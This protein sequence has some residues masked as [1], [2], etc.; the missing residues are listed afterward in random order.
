MA[1]RFF[2]A[3]GV[4]KTGEYSGSGQP[5]G[6]ITQYALATAPVGWLLCDGGQY[7]V[8]TYPLLD[9]LLGVT[10]GART[11]GFGS[12]GSTHF[13]V[14][15]A[16]GRVAVGAGTGAGGGT[17]GSGSVP[18]GGTA[19]TARSVSA[20]TGSERHTLSTGE[21]GNAAQAAGTSGT[22]SSDHS[23]SGTTGTESSDHTHNTWSGGGGAPYHITPLLAGT[24]GASQFATGGR[25]AA[26][27]HNFSTGGV[28]ANH[29]H[30]TPGVTGVGASGSHEN[31]QPIIVVSYIIKAT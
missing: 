8:A 16:R 5:I 1:W 23:H 20:W 27:T 6:A 15:D 30:T 25:S 31:T 10:Y 14:P 4:A 12:A 21:S 26:H 28:S 24:T 7:A 18:S 17:A 9:A 13:R 19:L 29:T 11:D 3:G 22:I 2:T